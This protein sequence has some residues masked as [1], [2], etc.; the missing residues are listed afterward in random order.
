MKSLQ[1]D[2]LYN[3]YSQYA[4][5]SGLKAPGSL[6]ELFSG[7]G[8]LWIDLGAV[9][10]DRIFYD[11]HL[12]C[13]RIQG[14]DGKLS[15]LGPPLGY[16]ALLYDLTHKDAATLYLDGSIQPLEALL[17]DLVWDLVP[18]DAADASEGPE[19]DLAGMCR[20]LRDPRRRAGIMD[21]LES[22]LGEV[23]DDL[24]AR[25]ERILYADRGPFQ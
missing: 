16:E 4:K 7:S 15:R 14:A 19:K 9:N 6:R 20:D 3:A 8:P 10:D 22:F 21:Y 1:K 12:M 24:E 2:W 17:L 11:T 13:Y 5:N 25:I 18:Y 23:Q